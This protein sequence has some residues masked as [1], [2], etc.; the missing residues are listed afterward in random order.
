MKQTDQESGG[1]IYAKVSHFIVSAVNVVN[2]VGKLLH[3]SSLT[4]LRPSNAIGGFSLENSW[5]TASQMKIFDA[6]AGVYGNKCDLCHISY[7]ML[8]FLLVTQQQIRCPHFRRVD[9]YPPKVVK[10]TNVPS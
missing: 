2:N 4:G 8:T 1:N 6:V 5:T 9:E 3:P 7:K 10:V